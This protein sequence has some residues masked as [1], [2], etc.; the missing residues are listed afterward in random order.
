LIARLDRG[1]LDR[2]S[3]RLAIAVLNGVGEKLLDYN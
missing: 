1:Q 2:L 3:T